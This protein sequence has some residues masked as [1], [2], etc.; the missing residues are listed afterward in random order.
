MDI[1]LIRANSTK[2]GEMRLQG[3]RKVGLKTVER[4]APT[5]LLLAMLYNAH[6]CELYQKNRLASLGRS[7]F[8][9]MAFEEPRCG[10]HFALFLNGGTTSCVSEKRRAKGANMENNV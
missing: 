1:Q 10:A 4:G 2:N 6:L 7:I 5:Y 3:R 8:L 9:L